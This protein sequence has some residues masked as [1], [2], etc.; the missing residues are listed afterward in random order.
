MNQADNAYHIMSE[1]SRVSIS[2][3]NHKG[4]T[5]IITSVYKV[6]QLVNTYQFQ[7]ESQ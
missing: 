1:L 7:F 2:S 3:T 5:K 4:T 6:I